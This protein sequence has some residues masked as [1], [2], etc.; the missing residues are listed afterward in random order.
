MAL[1]YYACLYED[2]YNLFNTSEWN[3]LQ[4]YI[5]YNLLGNYVDLFQKYGPNARCFETSLDACSHIPA[6]LDTYIV[7]YNGTG[8][9]AYQIFGHDSK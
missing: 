2:N 1:G 3:L 7:R 5:F 6:C 4:S 8:Q 9:L